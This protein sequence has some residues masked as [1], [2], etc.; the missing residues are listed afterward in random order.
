MNP[1]QLLYI[2]THIHAYNNNNVYKIQRERCSSLLF[3]I[4]DALLKH[5]FYYIRHIAFPHSVN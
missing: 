3:Y 2:Q 1:Q 4:Y 5:I